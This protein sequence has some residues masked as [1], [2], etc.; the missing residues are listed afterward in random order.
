LS[1][2]D[3][4]GLREA[5]TEVRGRLDEFAN[6]RRKHHSSDPQMVSVQT[7]V[8]FAAIKEQE[9]AFLAD[10]QRRAIER[11]SFSGRLQLEKYIREQIKTKIQIVGE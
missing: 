8:A 9:H 1:T 11:L 4:N 5:L 10:V 2:A 6:A 7:K 3:L